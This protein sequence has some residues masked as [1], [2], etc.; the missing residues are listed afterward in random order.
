MLSDDLRTDAMTMQSLSCALSSEQPK[1]Q[2][3]EP[4]HRKDNATFVTICY[5]DEHGATSRQS[6]V[7]G[8][9]AFGESFREG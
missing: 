3:A 2:L 4:E 7:G 8:V 6:S 9:L 5:R 1:S